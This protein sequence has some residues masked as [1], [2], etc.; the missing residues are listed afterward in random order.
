MNVL[1]STISK[2]F[3]LIILGL[4]SFSCE[5]N[6]VVINTGDKTFESC[7]VNPINSNEAEAICYED[8]NIIAKF[9]MKNNLINGEF[10]EW[11]SNGNLIKNYNYRNG[12]LYQNSF[13]YFENG[14]LSYFVH[15]GEEGD[16]NYKAIY[17][18]LGIIE[19]GYLKIESGLLN[20]ENINQGDS[21]NFYFK[22]PYSQFRN[23]K[24]LMIVDSYN[25]RIQ[26]DT[27]LYHGKE[28]FFDIHT[29]EKG[30][31][32]FKAYLQELDSLYNPGA[33]YPFKINYQ[34]L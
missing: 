14:V 11:N 2:G 29:Q 18:T 23:N 34:V 15:Y 31:Y 3:F 6:L 22:I 27:F 25:N 24:L 33:G 20:K 1:K 5:Q 7:K 12:N 16:F 30:K 17:D 21:I 4:T 13:E 8:S 10:K 26:R 32:V 9:Q 19:S 28:G